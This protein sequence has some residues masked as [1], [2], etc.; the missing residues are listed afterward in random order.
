MPL[1]TYQIKQIKH[2][3]NPELLAANFI[4]KMSYSPSLDFVRFPV[5]DRNLQSNVS[6]VQPYISNDFEENLSLGI[7]SAMAFI[8]FIGNAVTFRALQVG[9][10]IFSST[11][12]KLLKNQAVFDTI[13]C[14][15]GSIYVLQPPMWKTNFS[16]TF[17]QI[18]CQVCIFGYC[19]I[20]FQITSYS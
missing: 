15:L 5:T 17:D 20:R 18:I 8:G 19:D 1:D 2:L 6:T 3:T 4:F 7:Q 9:T 13:V 11:A 16:E 10:S 12:L 14:F